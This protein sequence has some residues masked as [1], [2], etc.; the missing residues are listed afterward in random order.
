MLVQAQ[1]PIGKEFLYL[2]IKMIVKSNGGL[3][4][5][6]FG[7]SFYN[8]GIVAEYVNA[9]GEIKEKSFNFNELNFVFISVKE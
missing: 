1:F 8:T 5:S 7:N 9:N 6:P 2:G 4:F 3:S